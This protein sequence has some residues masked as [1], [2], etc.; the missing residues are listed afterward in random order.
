MTRFW[1][2]SFLI[3]AGLTGDVWVKKEVAMEFSV[4]DSLKAR[5]KSQTGSAKHGRIIFKNKMKDLDTG[6]KGKRFT[7]PC[8]LELKRGKSSNFTITLAD[9]DH[10]TIYGGLKII[11]STKYTDNA[12]IP[13]EITYKILDLVAANEVPTITIKDPSWDASQDKKGRKLIPFDGGGP[14]GPVILTVNFGNRPR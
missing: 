14:S 8:R 6:E 13:I 7:L 5:I 12:M 10:T 11:R 3:I 2:V 4:G 9:E 1:I